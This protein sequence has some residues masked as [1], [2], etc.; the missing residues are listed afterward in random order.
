MGSLPRKNYDCAVIKTG[1]DEVCIHRK[2]KCLITQHGLYYDTNEG[3]ISWD[4]FWAMMVCVY[5][6]DPKMHVIVDED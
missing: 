6:L 4:K 2:F 3:V 1:D 5:G